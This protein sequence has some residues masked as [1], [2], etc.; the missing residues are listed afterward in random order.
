MY[1]KI[2]GWAI[3]L[4]LVALGVGSSSI[5]QP[6]KE[7]R[8]ALVIG[9]GDYKNGVP[10]LPNPVNDAKDI[11]SLLKQLE[12]E[13]ILITNATYPEVRDGVRKFYDQLVAGPKDQTVGLF[14][15]AGHGIQ[16]ENENYIVPIDAEMKFEDD[17]VRM[18]FPV[19]RI[20]LGSME[21]SNSAL[22]IVI[23]DACRNNPFPA[24]TRSL[25]SGL[26]EFQK[27]KGSFIAYATAPGSV[28]SD[29]TGENGL[30]TQELMK[31]MQIPGLPIEQVFKVV[32]RNVLRLSGEKQYTWDSSNILGDFYFMNSPENI[33]VA[34]NPVQKI[35]PPSLEKAETR[36]L[37]KK[38]VADEQ[39]ALELTN[40]TSTSTPFSKRQ[41]SR[42][43]LLK[44]FVV[45]HAWINVMIGERIDERIAANKLL[46]R[47][48][49][50][51]DTNIKVLTQETADSG[52]IIEL[53]IE[54]E[55]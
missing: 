49:T 13:V 41:L 17:I 36:Q 3:C 32:R 18:G 38:I 54:L 12:F 6:V 9:N 45:P 1:N 27:A 15:Y 53:F 4:M 47:L 30:Y 22:N 16:F 51:P 8:Y 24:T 10:K 40:L 52:R 42:T 19:Q 31:A 29:G 55:E 37:T 35:D 25:S 20:V 26:A 46:D 34:S 23:L 2:A 5:A 48:V 39:L 43:A 14:Y 21:R 28:A 50:L 44:Y 33:K 11:A 7:K